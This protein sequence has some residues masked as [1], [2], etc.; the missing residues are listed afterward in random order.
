MLAKFNESENPFKNDITFT[1]KR[2]GLS[3]LFL[4]SRDCKTKYSIQFGEPG[5]PEIIMKKGE[6]VLCKKNLKKYDP[7]SFIEFKL[8]I[9]NQAKSVHLFFGDEFLICKDDNI[10]KIKREHQLYLLFGKNSEHKKRIMSDQCHPANIKGRNSRDSSR[11]FPI[12]NKQKV[13][14]TAK[15]NDYYLYYDVGFSKGSSYQ[16]T[17]VKLVVGGWNNKWIKL[18]NGPKDEICNIKTGITHTEDFNL[19]EAKIDFSEK[20]VTVWINKKQFSCKYKA[21]VS[22]YFETNPINVRL[23]KFSGVGK[24]PEVCANAHF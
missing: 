4:S 22:K 2:K 12:Q 18:L 13:I 9:M 21:K 11:I 16:T 17:F 10:G 8:K 5:K 7:N 6:K 1:A 15:G 23:G 24:I 14:F 20:K 3:F 19:I